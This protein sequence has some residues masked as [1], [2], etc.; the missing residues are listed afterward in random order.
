MGDAS[1]AAK[2]QELAGNFVLTAQPLG[3]FTGAALLQVP[4]VKHEPIIHSSAH[5]PNPP[6]FIIHNF[7]CFHHRRLHFLLA[8]SEPI[9]TVDEGQYSSAALET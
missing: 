6:P 9:R 5:I 1:G 7:P 4:P 2:A 8:A 3:A